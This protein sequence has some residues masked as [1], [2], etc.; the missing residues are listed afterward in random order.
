MG[1][2]KKSEWIIGAEAKIR[3]NLMKKVINAH[4]IAEEKDARTKKRISQETEWKDETERN[5]WRD[6][7]MG[8]IVGDA[9]G[10][11]V[12]FLSRKDVQRA[13]IA[14]MNGFGTYD[15]PV[16]TW[17]DDGSMTIATLSSIKG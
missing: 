13:P 16:V 14:T 5:I 15:M 10:M 11:P 2:M 1:G 12:Q 4:S 3:G 6:G 9:L 7:I 8:V 17:S